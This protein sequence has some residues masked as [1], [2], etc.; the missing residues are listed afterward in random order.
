[1][2]SDGRTA[3]SPM[4]LCRRDGRRGGKKQ[5]AYAKAARCTEMEREELGE[6]KE[7]DGDG[8]G[9]REGGSDC[10]TQAAGS[11]AGQ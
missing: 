3:V 10:N 2:T 1:M 5:D 7:G 4:S 8:E 6:R 11:A 9:R